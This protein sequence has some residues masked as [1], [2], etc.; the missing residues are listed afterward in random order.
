VT[1]VVAD[2]LAVLGLAL[3]VVAGIGAHRLRDVFARLHASAVGTTA[4]TLLV[5]VAGALATPSLRRSGTLLLAALI[6][7][8][9]VP[10]AAHLLARSVDRSRRR[11]AEAGPRDGD[12]GHRVVGD[13]GGRR[14]GE[15]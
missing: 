14:G 2:A 15:H 5:L 9:T 11:S 13:Q 10:A 1:S 6:V 8:A 3:L 12:G 7:T 4:G